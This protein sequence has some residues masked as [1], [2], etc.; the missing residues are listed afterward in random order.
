L[1]TK[2]ETVENKNRKDYATEKWEQ[3]VRQSLTKKKAA[4]VGASLSK[5]DKALVAAQLAKEAETRMRISKLQARLRRGVELVSSLVVSNAEKME[6]H[7]G[8]LAKM[9]LVTAFGAG[10]FLLD[11]RPFDV[12]MVSTSFNIHAGPNDIS[13]K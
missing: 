9:M 5:Q 6:R 7:V 2:K 13:S 4:S 1:S 10:S 3:E 8:E 12:F 11:G